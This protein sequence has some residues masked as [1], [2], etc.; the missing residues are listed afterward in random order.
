MP[1]TP[2]KYQ[3]IIDL[4]TRRNPD[5]SMLAVFVF[6]RNDDENFSKVV[7]SYCR[8]KRT[9]QNTWCMNSVIVGVFHVDDILVTLFLTGELHW[10][11]VH[12]FIDYRSFTFQRTHLHSQRKPSLPKPNPTPK[13]TVFNDG[14]YNLQRYP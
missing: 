4:E 14:R 12:F 8:E 7:S 9:K 11:F 3:N 1:N 2:I 5:R 6:G 13:G 10:L